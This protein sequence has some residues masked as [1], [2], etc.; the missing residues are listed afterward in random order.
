[1]CR[2]LSADSALL[3]SE[4][5]GLEGR[6]HSRGLSRNLTD[7]KSVGYISFRFGSLVPKGNRFEVERFPRKVGGFVKKA[8][9]PPGATAAETFDLLKLCSSFTQFRVWLH[10]RD[11]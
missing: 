3:I 11:P 10:P 5:L 2:H 8:A 4:L 6:N 7:R 1:M 9:A